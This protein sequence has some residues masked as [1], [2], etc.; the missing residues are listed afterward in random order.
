MGGRWKAV[1][2]P[3]TQNLQANILLKFM[4]KSSAQRLLLTVAGMLLLM[5]SAV[6]AQEAGCSQSLDDAEVAYFNGE[7]D[8]AISMIEPCLNSEDYSQAQGVRAYSLLGGIQFVLGEEDAARASIEGLYAVD[9]AF[10]PGP[11][12]PPNFSAL[13]LD[14]K[15]QMIADGRFPA[16]EPEISEPDTPL[17]TDVLPVEAEGEE[18]PEKSP[19]K[20]KA[21]FVGG[22]A[23]LA[24]A[25]GAAILLSGN[26][27]GGP[28]TKTEWPFPPGHP[29][30]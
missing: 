27:G 26:S 19:R 16:L 28:D 6:F 10:V 9:P 8:R 13:I 15:Q 14:V 20:R 18:V 11:E 22:G 23:A 24:V 4:H 7:F 3:Y 29:S 30:Q 1:R 12:L 5:P 2:N 17:V 25:A 21:L